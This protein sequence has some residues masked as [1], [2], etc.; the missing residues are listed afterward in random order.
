MPSVFLSHNSADKPFVEKLAN[1][2]KRIGVNV[3]FDKWEIKVGESL[4]W[5]IEQGIRENEYLA[6]ILSPEAIQSEWVRCELSSA[7]AKQMQQ[8]KVVVLPILY[9]DC[10]VPLF[11]LDR[12]YADFRNDYQQGFKEFAGSLGVEETDTIS[13]ENWRR[14]ARSRVGDWQKYRKL[15]FEQLVTILVDR[16][17]EYNWS[18]WVGVTSNPY[19]ITLSAFIDIETKATVTLKL[20]GRTYA[21]KASLKDVLSP[22]DIRASEFNIYVGNKINE[23][24]E[25][26]WRKME[27]FKS[28]YGNPAGEAYHYVDRFLSEREKWTVANRLVNELNSEMTW[29]KGKKAVQK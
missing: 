10:E 5:K 9:R 2:L 8:K 1:D 4:T 12:R 19:S 16:A 13:I 18:S 20:D 25:F 29:Y 22:K 21:Y 3:W 7:W 14:F 28:R 15:E 24:E 11:L 26:V 6:I 17:S 23:C 27:D